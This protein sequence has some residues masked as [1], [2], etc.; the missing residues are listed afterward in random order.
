MAVT[1]STLQLLQA[2]R[3]VVG[4]YADE[5]VRDLAAQWVQAWA[6]IAPTWQQAIAVLVGWAAEHGR[7]PTP[8][9]LVR[10]EQV[11]Q[12]TAA[13]AEELDALAAATTAACVAAA[14]AAIAATADGE[15]GVFA[16]QLPPAYRADGARRFGE[17]ILPTALDVIRVRVT[18]A[19]VAQT[20]PLSADA[21]A[22]MRRELV[23]GVRVGANPNETARRMVASV[24]GAFEGGLDRATVIARTEV[25]DSYRT[26]SRYAHDANADVLDGWTWIATVTGKSATRTCPACWAMH[27]RVF[28][29]NTSGPDGHQQCRCARLPHAKPWRALGIDLD[30]PDDSTPDRQAA[31]DALDDAGR[32]QVMGAARLALFDA[33][34][35]GWEDI[36]VLRENPA[37]RRS[38][39][40]RPLRDL[41]RIADNRRT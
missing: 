1:S 35:I 25:L 30:E 6:R 22:A 32:L 36:P 2:M 29:V 13:A 4:G 16:S 37:W 33:G 7:W 8:V 5:A 15:P 19:I 20:R 3:T 18:Q 38:Y 11:G 34:L 28:P 27:S 26:A 9:E 39:V 17:R 21:Q 24:N 41:N 40:P 31:F 12:A 23:R 14:V 10:V